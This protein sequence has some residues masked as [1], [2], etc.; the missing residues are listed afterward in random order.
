MRLDI[1]VAR[2]ER[3]NTAALGA[4]MVDQLLEQ[5]LDVLARKATGVLEESTES[6]L[7]ESL[8]ASDVLAVVIPLVVVQALGGLEEASQLETSVGAVAAA[9]AVDALGRDT[10]SKDSR[11]DESSELHSESYLLVGD[12]SG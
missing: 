4:S 7:V 9:M 5:L 3:R 8:P 1:V 12:N 6:G 10:K 11:S 2:V